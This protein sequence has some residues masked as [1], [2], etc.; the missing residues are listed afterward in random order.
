[1]N[2]PF[3]PEVR[4]EASQQETTTQEYID[5]LVHELGTP[6]TVVLGYLH[7][8]REAESHS[9]RAHDYFD[10][11]ERQCER[12]QRIISDLLH[13][14]MLGALPEAPRDKHVDILEV[15][16]QI[17]GGAHALSQGCHRIVLDA[18]A[19]FDLLGAETELARALNNLV[20]NAIRYTPHGGEVRLIWRASTQGAEFVVED[21]GIG[22]ATEHITRL[23]ERFYRVARQRSPDS[24]GAGLGLA[25]VKSVLDRHQATLEIESVRGQG[26]RF[27]ARFPA[28]RV[29][30]VRGRIRLGHR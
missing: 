24:G 1:M 8:A 6:L 26:S 3:A 4:I 27:T 19:G 11:I 14:S 18:Q 20:S 13:L 15:L 9:A 23:T 7:A 16:T 2:G 21:T 28:A 12:M 29:A 22:I 17:Q 10:R 25:I 30:P 5:H